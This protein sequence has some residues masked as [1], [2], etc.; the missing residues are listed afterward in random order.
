MKLPSKVIPYED[1]TLSHL[2]RILKALKKNKDKKMTPFELYDDVG[3]YF[4]DTSEY[5]EA[6]D[7]LYA[8]QAI[9]F[10]EKKGIIHYAL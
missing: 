5:I 1:S 2:P 7:C 4:I 8:L 10:D 9:K 6:L 3:K